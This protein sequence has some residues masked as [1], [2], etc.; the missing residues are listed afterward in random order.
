M[1]TVMMKPTEPNN[2]KWTAIVYMMRKGVYIATYLAWP[3][4]NISNFYSVRNLL[5]CETPKSILGCF[6]STLSTV[7]T[8]FRRGVSTNVLPTH[9]FC[10]LGNFVSSLR[11]VCVSPHS[12]SNS[13]AMFNIVS[14]SRS[15]LFCFIHTI[16]ISFFVSISNAQSVNVSGAYADFTG[17]LNDYRASVY[18]DKTESPDLMNVVID[19]PPGTLS[20]RNGY[21]VCGHIPS[22]NTATNIFEYSKNNGSKVLIVTDNTTVWQTANCSE[23]TQIRTSMNA[24]SVPRFA[25]IRDKLWMTNGHDAPATWDGVTLNVLDGSGTL[26]N[27]PRGKLIAW[28]KDRVWI[29]NTIGETSAVY[30]SATAGTDGSVLDPGVSSQAWTNTSNLVYFGR[31]DGSQLYGLKVYRDNL[32]AF[33]DTGI[34]RLIF[35]SEFNT[36][37]VK[38][39]SKIGSKFQESIVEMDDSFLRFVGRDGVYKFDGSTVQR[40]STKWNTTFKTLQQ[41]NAVQENYN[42]WNTATLFDAGTQTGHRLVHTYDYPNGLVLSQPTAAFDNVGAESNNTSNWSAVSIWAASSTR[43]YFGT[44]SFVHTQTGVTSVGSVDMKVYNSNDTEIGS[45]Q[46]TGGLNTWVSLACYITAPVTSVT[47]TIYIVVSNRLTMGGTSATATMTSQKF[48]IPVIDRY[49]DGSLYQVYVGAQ[50]YKQSSG[51]NVSVFFDMDETVYTPLAV[52]V[53]PKFK[54]TDISAWR[55]F[56]VDNTLNGGTEVFGVRLG[57]SSSMLDI[58]PYSA[59]LSGGQVDTVANPWVQ[60]KSTFTSTNRSAPVILNA[61]TINWLTGLPTKSLLS[62]INYKSRYWVA[63]ST[64]VGGLY[65][66]MVMIESRPPVASH[67]KYDLKLS[68]MAIWNS[69]LYAAISNSSAIA[70]VD[71][72]TTDGGNAIKA[73]W[74]SRDDVFENPLAYKSINKAIVDYASIPANKSLQVALSPD[75]GASYGTKTVDVTRSGQLRY[76]GNINFD[77]NRALQF[78]TRVYNDQL[79]IG[80]KIYG[81]H[82]SGTASG[83]MGN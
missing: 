39:V 1:D 8:L 11:R 74:A 72:G 66:D 45:C 18:L 54:A 82:P 17:G 36:I 67:T 76:T 26:P 21:Q 14:S 10:V 9:P 81:I 48:T 2:T 29:G 31:G 51:G 52:Y 64:T 55:T 69:N 6:V 70:R 34:F 23:F 3:F 63:G 40:T 78:R 20:Q 80:F 41:P 42:T 27:V 22:G 50:Y 30:F 62:G 37:S 15:S 46:G 35:Q 5:S 16:I 58:T 47:S 56:D 24:D 60:W 13:C 19:E 68:A 61:A 73:W 28:W 43:K 77:A 32:Y 38:N 57:T 53:S 71:Y 83:F 79:G 4:K 65:N 49:G 12:G 75:F 44:Y 25:I 33:K 7:N 59:I